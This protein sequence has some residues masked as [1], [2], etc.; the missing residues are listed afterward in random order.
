[1]SDSDIS[2]SGRTVSV[3]GKTWQAPWPVTQAAVIDDR[4]I[5]LYDYMAGPRDRQFQN[6]EA[7]NSSGQHLWT[8]QHPTAEKPDTYVKILSTSP[9]LAWNFACYKCTIDV[10]SGRLV[11]ALF[12]K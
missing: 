7:F 4:V 2:F 12:T 9:F 5:L 3:A 6:L 8:A 11:K 10:S 1:M